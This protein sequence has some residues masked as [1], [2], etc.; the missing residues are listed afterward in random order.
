[1]NFLKVGNSSIGLLF[2]V[3]SL[4]L[5]SSCEKEVELKLSASEDLIVVEG[6]IES[7]LPPYLLLTKNSGYFSAIDL[8][9]LEKLFI[10]G[11]EIWVNDG[12][13]SAQLTEVSTDT[14]PPAYSNLIGKQLGY[15]NNTLKLYFYAILNPFSPLIGKENTTY[16]LHIKSNGRTVYA[17]T[18]IPKKAPLDS[19][20][21]NFL[22]APRD[23][24]ARLY[25]HYSDPVEPENYTRMFTSRN[26]EPYYSGFGS[27][28]EDKII[29][30]LSFDFAIDRNQAP[31]SQ[32]NRETYGFFTKGDTANIKWCSIDRTTFD[33]WRSLESQVNQGGSP[34]SSV[35]RIKSN[36]HGG[37]G[38]WCGYGSTFISRVIE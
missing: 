32:I 15:G 29:N 25:A 10:H 19:L 23:T 38:I 6:Y 14:L 33:Y 3:A 22:D 36:I 18:T 13:D 7:G 17:S 26:S 12:K 11:A 31:N 20:Y 37:A 16:N 30:G 34:F 2:W 21:Y 8:K 9:N 28:Y 1:M 4:I 24:L 27:V 5:L 35:I